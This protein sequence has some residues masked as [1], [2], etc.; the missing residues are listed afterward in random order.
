[1]S[2][3]KQEAIK[4]MQKLGL[5]EDAIKRFDK[6]NRLMCSDEGNLKEVPEN[7]LEMINAWEKKYKNM[8]YHVIHSHIYGCETYECLSVSKYPEDW[9]YESG[10]V[11]ENW[12]MS[13][14]I[15]LTIPAFSESGTILVENYKGTLMRVG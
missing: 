13:H 7:I 2:Q 1:M 9:N 3:Q 5:S 11:D 12:P 15:N 4:R 6:D 8:V 10:R 14:S